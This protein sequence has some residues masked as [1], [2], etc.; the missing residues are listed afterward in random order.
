MQLSERMRDITLLQQRY[1]CGGRWR[2][3]LSGAVFA[4]DDP[5]TGALIARVPNAGEPDA[6]AAI[7][8]AE[9]ALPAWRALTGKERARTMRRWYDLLCE[10]ADDLAVLISAEEGKPL[11]EAHGEVGYGVSFVEWFA[12]EAKRVDGDVLQS[13]Q[14][15]KRLLALKQPIGICAS[16]TPWNFPLAMI[17][18]KVAP[19]LAAGCTIVVKPAEQ[20]P[21]TALA[22]GELALRAGIPAG[23]L[24]ILTA[25]A[26]NSIAVGKILTGD[27][28]VAHLSFT[29][30]TEVGRIL[31]RQCAST[32]KKVALELGGHA[33]FIVFDDADLDSALEGALTAKYRNAGQACIAPNRFYVQAR[34]HDRFVTRIAERSRALRVGN[35]F[36]PG[37]NIGPLIDAQAVAKVRQHVDDATRRGAQVAAGGC[38]GDCSY[39]QPTV[40]T[41]VT[42]EMLISREE[43]FGPVIAV[44]RFETEAEVL[45]LANHREYGLAAYLYTRDLARAWRVAEGLEFGMV[46]INAGAI[47]NEVAPFGGV[48]Q[49]GLGREGSKY[50]IEEYLEMKYLCVG[51]Q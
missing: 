26:A 8:A 34:I 12:E 4:V 49:S 36:D 23:V 11:A 40:L 17:T 19:A 30:S 42:Q 43:T 45:A 2:D 47:S 5:A 41:G 18:R 3:A 15:D 39:F 37:I 20:T 16:I 13:P 50:G 29:G 28:R 9:Q 14:S 32:I 6:V 46:G 33:P 27:P 25:D 22:I 35:G 48:K 7:D 1:L 21:L 38:S 44:T 10:H 31:M 24:N 51:L